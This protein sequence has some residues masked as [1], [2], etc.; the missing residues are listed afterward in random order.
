MNGK[1]QCGINLWQPILTFTV[2]NFMGSLLSAGTLADL[3]A[4]EPS[5]KV[6]NI[7][8][9]LLQFFASLFL[10]ITAGKDPATIP[11]REFLLRAYQGKLDTPPEEPRKKYL[12]V[13]NG[14]LTKIKYCNTCD[15]YRPPRAIHCGIC[16]CCIERLDHHCPW[17]GTCIGK[18]NYKY[19]LCFVWLVTIMVIE[20][21][22]FTAFHIGSDS[23][24]QVNL[25]GELEFSSL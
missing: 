22:V 15:L 20:G 8:F 23:F 17:L 13:V 19:F 5:F 21:I 25:E 9:L 10:F 4:R 7:Q 18:R 16:N 3:A 2:I 12:S 24:S 1:I 14:R 6:V 11:M